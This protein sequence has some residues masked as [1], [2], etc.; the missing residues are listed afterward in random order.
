MYL[1]SQFREDDT[2]TLAAFIDANPFATLVTQGPS[3][4]EA[5]HL[6]LLRLEDARGG[7]LLQGHIARANDWWKT[8]SADAAVLVI[9]E[10]PHRYITPTWYPTKAETGEVVPTWNYSVVHAHGRIRFVEDPTWTRELVSALTDRHEAGRPTPWRMTDAPESYLE[11]MLQMIVGFEVV[12]E[13]LEGKFKASQNRIP[14][15]RE[16]VAMGLAADG[17]PADRIQQLVRS[18]QTP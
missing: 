10:G 18:K 6:P 13:R 14:R 1:P 11:S 3:G 8:T 16:G 4:L 5:N 15:D 2:A 9:F 7:L 17:E 12:V